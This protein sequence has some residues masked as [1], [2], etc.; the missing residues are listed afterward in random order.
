VPVDGS[1]TLDLNGMV[2]VIEALK[3]PLVI[4]MHYFGAVTLNR[5]LDRMRD[6]FAVEFAATPSLVISKATLPTQPKVVV[7]PGR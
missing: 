2:E 4:P 6:K 3:A 5:F 7:L 1:F